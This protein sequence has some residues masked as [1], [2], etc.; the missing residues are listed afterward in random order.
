MIKAFITVAVSLTMVLVGCSTELTPEQLEAKEFKEWSKTVT[1]VESYKP[2][3]WDE[4]A[5]VE[6]FNSE[7]QTI[8]EAIQE[9]LPAQR[10]TVNVQDFT[11]PNWLYKL[12]SV[13]LDENN[14]V[15][16]EPL[17]DPI[18]GSEVGDIFVGYVNEKQLRE[19]ATKIGGQF[20][21]APLDE[22]LLSGSNVAPPYP[23]K[24]FTVFKETIN[25]SIKLQARGDWNTYLWEGFNEIDDP[26]RWA[27]DEYPYPDG[28]YTPFTLT[29][30]YLPSCEA[31][32]NPLFFSEED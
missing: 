4:T 8:L 26:G 21:S 25:F 31:Q 29:V 1:K 16:K 23:F 9:V 3:K 27:F 15:I 7:V 10:F 11:K 17:P 30:K 12:C 18:M 32:R 28:N 24:S 14:E 6:P 2:V 22:H 13:Q 20:E 19:I 5:T